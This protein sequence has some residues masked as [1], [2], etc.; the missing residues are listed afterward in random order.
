M[1]LFIMMDAI[2]IHVIMMSAR[3]LKRCFLGVLYLRLPLPLPLPLLL[4]M[5]AVDFR[6]SST[7]EL[8]SDFLRLPFPEL[9]PEPKQE[10]KCFASN[11]QEIPC[12]KDLSVLV[13]C[14]QHPTTQALNQLPKNC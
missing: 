6:L 2:K 11:P 3:L 5:P 1:V 9:A 14:R 12:N 13:Q 7:S 4:S 8:T 10:S